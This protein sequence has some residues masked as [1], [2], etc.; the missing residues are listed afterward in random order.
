MAGCVWHV[1]WRHAWQGAC[2]AGEKATAADGTHPTGMHSCLRL[3]TQTCPLQFEV[4]F[5]M[6]AGNSGKTNAVEGSGS[7]SEPSDSDIDS[8]TDS[9]G[10]TNCRNVDFLHKIQTVGN[11]NRVSR[12]KYSGM[13]VYVYV[14]L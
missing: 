11:C 8:N 9:D 5:V 4:S 7:G 12:C 6:K 14:L 2:V 1:W 10:D 13:Y 3:L